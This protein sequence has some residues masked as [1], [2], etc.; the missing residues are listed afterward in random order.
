MSRSRTD[1]F[2][3]T[4]PHVELNFDNFELNL[5]LATS[6]PAPRTPSSRSSFRLPTS[7]SDRL[8]AL[9]GDRSARNTISSS[10]N[11]PGDTY[12]MESDTAGRPES[13]Q[14]WSTPTSQ[15]MPSTSALPSTGERTV[16]D[17]QS[18]RVGEDNTALIS[19][20]LSVAAA[21]TA[22]TLLDGDQEA[23]AG[24]HSVNGDGTFSNFLQSLES[25]RL[26]SALRQGGQSST[27]APLNFFRMFGF[28]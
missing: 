21:T 17:G 24:A 1:D 18:R 5:D 9:R 13:S 10:R 14:T 25:G 16:N 15:D 23:I 8:S 11:Q 2:G 26:A 4:F 3:Y 7:L 28:G 22:A 19:R 12:N 27:A 20:I 6:D